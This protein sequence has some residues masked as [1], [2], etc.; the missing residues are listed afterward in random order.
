MKKV[1]IMFFILFS[2]VVIMAGCNGS[3]DEIGSM[4]ICN[5]DNRGYYI[6]IIRD[7]D[8]RVME[9]FYVDKFYHLIDNCELIY[10]IDSGDYYISFQDEYTGVIT[11]SDTFYLR[12]GVSEAFAI[13]EDGYIE[14]Y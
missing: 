14:R 11:L 10:H 8:D 4:E 2:L 12:E 3:D 13:N 1:K 5:F 9:S 7:S 6:E